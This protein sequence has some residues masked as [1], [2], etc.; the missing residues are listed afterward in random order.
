MNFPAVDTWPM[1]LPKLEAN[2]ISASGPQAIAWGYESF[3]EKG[4][5]VT[6]PDAVMRS[7]AAVGTMP[8]VD[9]RNQ[10][11]PSGPAVIMPRTSSKTPQT[12][13]CGNSVTWPLVVIR[14]IASRVRYHMAPSGPAVMA[15]TPEPA[16]FGGK[17][18]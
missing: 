1:E 13:S 3:V 10:R 15:P 14:P 2:Q 5:S 8:G 12:R 11:L 18:K 7:I 6:S 9:P 16:E 17:L 4:I